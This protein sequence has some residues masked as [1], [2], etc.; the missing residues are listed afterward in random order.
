[1]HHNV[2]AEE[3][4]ARNRNSQSCTTTFRQAFH[5]LYELMTIL[6]KYFWVQQFISKSVV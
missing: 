4:E 3:I 2:F 6:E 1:M 5:E